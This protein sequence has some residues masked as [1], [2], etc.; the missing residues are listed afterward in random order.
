MN[1]KRHRESKD[2]S[3]PYNMKL[4]RARAVCSVMHN[5]CGVRA[6]QP[7]IVHASFPL[8]IPGSATSASP[9]RDINA[10]FLT[11]AFFFPRIQPCRATIG[12]HE[13]D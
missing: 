12:L 11:L 3:I 10:T 2:I 4:A 9:F 13:T 7:S 6:T 8:R 5:D 1:Y